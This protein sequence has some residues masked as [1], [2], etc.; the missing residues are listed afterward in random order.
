MTVRNYIKKRRGRKEK[1]R[2]D[3]A[4][5]FWEFLVELNATNLITV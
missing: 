5:R 4:G 2:G 3:P 1:A